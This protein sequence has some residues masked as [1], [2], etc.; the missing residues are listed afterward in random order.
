MLL[1]LRLAGRIEITDRAS[2][3]SGRKTT[4]MI[5]SPRNSPIAT[6]SVYRDVNGRRE[7]RTTQ[8]GGMEIEDIARQLA[9]ELP[10][11]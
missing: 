10:K 1:S 9:S 7:Q 4:A 6:I 2:E 3:P 11:A 8:V 5:V